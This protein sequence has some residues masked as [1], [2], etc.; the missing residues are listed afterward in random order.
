MCQR[1][2]NLCRILCSLQNAVDFHFVQ[3][4]GQQKMA[5]SVSDLVILS[6]A[7]DKERRKATSTRVK[8][9]FKSCNSFLA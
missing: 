8:A 2:N 1:F 6:A 4:H 7:F 3:G 9:D 5:G